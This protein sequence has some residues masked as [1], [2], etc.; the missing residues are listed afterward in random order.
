MPQLAQYPRANPARWWKTHHVGS[1]HRSP[2]AMFISPLRHYSTL[3][4]L[5]ILATLIVGVWYIT[6]PK[7]ISRL[8]EALLSVVLGAQAH[9]ENGHLSFAGTLMLSNVQ[10]KTP[11]P[12]GESLNL[13][14]A[15]QVEVRFDWLSLIT[16]ELR[17]T[18]ITAVRPTLYLIEDR[19]TNHWNYEHLQKAPSGEGSAQPPVMITSLPFIVLRDAR[20]Q[21]AEINNGLLKSTAATIIDGQL[22]P[23]PH[24]SMVY[25][26]QMDERPASGHGGTSVS[27]HWDV[28]HNTFSAAT[29]PINLA[30]LDLQSL[31][32][33][34]RQWWK[35]HDLS[36]RVAALR[37]T[38]DRESGL[39]LFIDLQQVSM[40]QAIDQSITH[41]PIVKLVKFSN[42][43]GALLFNV[44]HSKLQVT[45][46]TGSVLGYPFIINAEFGGLSPNAPFDLHLELPNANINPEYPDLI[47]NLQITADIIARVRPSGLADISLHIERPLGGGH[48]FTSGKIVCKNVSARLAY[49]PYPVKI[50][51]N[52]RHPDALERGTIHIFDDHITVDRF[53]VQADETMVEISGTVG[54]TWENQL[55][56]ITAHCEHATIDDRMK[57]CLP[58]N[59]QEI[60]EH[61]SPAGTGKFSIHVARAKSAHE[62]PSIVVTMEPQDIQG[63]YLGFPYPLKHLHGKI[64]FGDNQTEVV[65]LD[66]VTGQDGS[67]HIH[68]A[69]NVKYPQGGLQNVAPHVTFIA[70]H[71][72]VDAT[73]IT[74]LPFSYRQ[75]ADRA[76]ITGLIHM[77]GLISNNPSHE[78]IVTGNLILSAAALKLKDIDYALDHLAAS[79]NLTPDV[80]DITRLVASPAGA[81][82]A[83]MQLAA[84]IRQTSKDVQI[85]T[86]GQFTAFPL[87]ATAPPGMPEIWSKKWAYYKPSGHVDGDFAMKFVFPNNEGAIVGASKP[88]AEPLGSVAALGM[89]HSEFLK[90][91]TFHLRPQKM[92]FA[93]TGWPEALTG[94]TGQIGITPQKIEI[95]DLAAHASDIKMQLAGIYLPP[96]DV[97]R[98][99]LNVQSPTLPDKWFGILPAN[100]RDTLRSMKLESQW[101]LRLDKLSWDG[102]AAKPRW[103]FGG[104]I[105]LSHLKMQSPVGAS[106]D[107]IRIAG[108]GSYDPA[109]AGLDFNGNLSSPTLGLTNRTVDTLAA[110]IVAVAADKSIALNDIS[111][112]VA[113]GTLNGN[114]MVSLESPAR[115][116]AAM[117]L[118]DADVAILA[119]GNNANADERKRLGTGRLTANLSV[120]Q[121]FGPFGERTGR[122]D[123]VV[124]DGNLFH[125]PLAM[126]LMQIVTL[127]LPVSGAFK[128]ASMSYYLRDN[129]ITFEKI[130]FESPGINLAGL[131]TLSLQD[132]KLDLNFVT[133]SPKEMSLPIIFDITKF[134]RDQILQIQVT[135]TVE[136]PRIQPVQLNALTAPI[137]E[138]LPKRKPTQ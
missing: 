120:Q 12:S 10:L 52:S 134:I 136:N 56:D 1:A 41:N 68:F 9:V 31:P 92:S 51:H 18:Q 17:A 60:W 116:E 81:T 23:D 138:L 89:A 48:I 96:T 25:T 5:V 124:R 88:A 13:F 7:R 66:G 107:K 121:Q 53:Q 57:A 28:G 3:V 109:S 38:L 14:S 85:S 127:R 126:G 24:Q 64:I 100:F 26:F 69:G 133:E 65:G 36:G 113:G 108:I 83:S 114:I 42:V 82:D 130:L 2:A 45:N 67:G 106:M 137:R 112:S 102:K 104:Q 19:A 63:Y 122:G 50:V 73:L 37:T 6:N 46:L 103:D 74:A 94:I 8:S 34:V 55:L 110:N 98:L 101:A 84:L 54:T 135:G 118:S 35:D 132:R 4:T 86:E 11:G 72:P 15:D 117:L 90:D 111:G 62:F 58:E 44:T 78:T 71:V 40:V 105:D 76:D 43:S 20:V 47:K 61:F 59:I 125:V 39:N 123:L 128:N 97:L 93:P 80:I 75:W 115:Y 21:W 16:G 29:L 70:D 32:R 129:K 95:T 30:E 79:I 91:Y 49:F 87:P 33:Q 27:G 131:G 22:S 119:L 77:D 99:A